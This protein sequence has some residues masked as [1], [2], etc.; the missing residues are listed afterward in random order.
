M[1][2]LV[3]CRW[4]RRK[5]IK[6]NYRP[7]LS[8]CPSH[9]LTYTNTQE[10]RAIILFSLG[11]G[12]WKE[13]SHWDY[14]YNFYLFVVHTF[15]PA[16]IVHRLL[17][18]MEG[19]KIKGFDLTRSQFFIFASLQCLSINYMTHTHS[20]TWSYINERVDDSKKYIRFIEWKKNFP[21]E[22]DF[23][24]FFPASPSPALI[25][26]RCENWRMDSQAEAAEEK[27]MN[28]SRMCVQIE[29]Y[30]I[31]ENIERQAPLT[32]HILC[33]F[34]N[35]AYFLV[36]IR[37]AHSRLHFLRVHSEGEKN[38]C[39]CSCVLKSSSVSLL[40]SLTLHPSFSL[41]L[42]LYLTRSP[43]RSLSGI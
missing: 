36:V 22:K 1:P 40:N 42:S 5:I 27:K 15:H 41:S 35:G 4:L 43:I 23:C 3:K 31:L 20:H 18:W 26:L 16:A 7:L 11:E 8:P 14:E 19:K 9:S 38:S 30:N 17:R 32:Q 33:P 24:C 29:L 25:R 2:S 10:T 12:K 21:F 37:E 34:S 13:K 39:C 6:N 28:E